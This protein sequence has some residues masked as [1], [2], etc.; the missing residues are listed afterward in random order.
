MVTD[1]PKVRVEL[2]KSSRHMLQGCLTA[3][4]LNHHPR[5]I[6]EGVEDEVEV[7][8]IMAPV[9]Q[10]VPL[11]VGRHAECPT[12][13]DSGHDACE[14]VLLQLGDGDHGANGR[15]AAPQGWGGLAEDDAHC[16]RVDAVGGD[17]EV[18]LGLRAVGQV[19]DALLGLDAD[20]LCV[21]EKAAWQVRGVPTATAVRR[22]R[23]RQI[24]QLLA[25]V[26]S[27][28]CAAYGFLYLQ[29]LKQLQCPPIEDL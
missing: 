28:D 5:Y 6:L 3:H 25:Q 9:P 19:D 24:P 23:F 7:L 26:R 22:W 14:G 12:A 15:V 16:G 4:F 8:E 13:G 21:S 2:V 27:I 10:Q 20:H 18:C 29:D 17:D 11:A 1:R